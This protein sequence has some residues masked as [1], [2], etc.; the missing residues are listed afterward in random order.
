MR[1]V[2]AC[3]TPTCDERMRG[4]TDEPGLWCSLCLE[5]LTTI[6]LDDGVTDSE[7]VRPYVVESGQ[8]Q[9]GSEG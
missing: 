7:V 9:G 4:V 3:T 2:Y 1:I 8:Q 5:D 6:A